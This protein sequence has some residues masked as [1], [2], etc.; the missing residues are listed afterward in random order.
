MSSN[1][2]SAHLV[3]GSVVPTSLQPGNWAVVAVK[4]EC[5]EHSSMDKEY[6]SDDCGRKFPLTQVRIR[7]DRIVC[8]SCLAVEER[9]YRQ[10]YSSSGRS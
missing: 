2:M 5:F 6:L 1:S 10:I 3:V 7:G 8:G 4:V 9:L